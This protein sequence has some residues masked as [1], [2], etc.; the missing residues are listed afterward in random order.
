MMTNNGARMHN[1]RLAQFD[2]EFQCE[3]PINGG[4]GFGEFVRFEYWN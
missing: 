3:A 4:M 1:V 2:T